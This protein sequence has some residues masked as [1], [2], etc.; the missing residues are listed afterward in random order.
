MCQISYIKPNCF[1]LWY[2]CD[3]SANT[4]FGV[5]VG[6][7]FHVDSVGVGADLS[8]PIPRNSP[9]WCCN[10]HH[11]DTLKPFGLDWKTGA[12]NRPLRL[13]V[14]SLPYICAKNT[15]HVGIRWC[16]FPRWFRRRRGR[17]IVPV[18]TNTHKMVLRISTVGI[19]IRTILH[20][21]TNC[22]WLWCGRDKSANTPCGLFVAI[23]LR[24][25][26]PTRGCLQPYIYNRKKVDFV[27]EIYWSGFSINPL[28]CSSNPF[29]MLL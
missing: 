8:C 5:F 15:P 14:C 29:S 19:A 2:G 9:K 13:A 23:Y 16:I 26:Y 6:V 17:F 10:S 25:K 22:F 12:M 21:K 7:F 1:W 18:S 27:F 20:T 3:E 11:F 28:Y 24:K 4:S